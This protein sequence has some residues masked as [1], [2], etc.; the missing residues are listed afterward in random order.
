MTKRLQSLKK[1]ILADRETRTAYEAMADE[2]GLARELITARVRAGS[3]KR[4][5]QNAWKPHSL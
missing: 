5:S 4:N 3:P 1:K 2:F